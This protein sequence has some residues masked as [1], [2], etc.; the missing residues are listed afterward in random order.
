MVLP[1]AENRWQQAFVAV[2][3]E[4]N[5]VTAKLAAVK[6]WK[7]K[8]G[9]P[10]DLPVLPET[11]EMAEFALTPYARTNACIALFPGRKQA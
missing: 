4:D 10:A 8:D 7:V 5:R 3:E 2:S 11:A 6:E 9:V 1:V